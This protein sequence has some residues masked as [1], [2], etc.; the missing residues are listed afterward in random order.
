MIGGSFLV[1]GLPYALSHY[2]CDVWCQSMSVTLGP[3]EPV[4]RIL[5]EHPVFELFMPYGFAILVVGIVLYF[6]YKVELKEIP[7]P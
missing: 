3:N 6:A 7:R 4:G 2:D 5:A 1:T